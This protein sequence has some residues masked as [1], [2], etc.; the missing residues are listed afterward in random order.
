MNK[1]LLSK[2]VLYTFISAFVLSSLAVSSSNSAFAF[3]GFFL[4]DTESS[5]GEETSSSTT[6]KSN[7][8][9]SSDCYSPYGSVINSCN[10]DGVSASQDTGSRSLVQ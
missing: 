9:Q 8:L 3:L 6:Q 10:S 7:S 2:T 1:K 5:V 4:D